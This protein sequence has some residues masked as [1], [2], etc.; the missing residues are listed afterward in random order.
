MT[1]GR[2][3]QVAAM[4]APMPIGG[5]RRAIDEITKLDRLACFHSRPTE[6]TR[7][8]SFG[9]TSARTVQTHVS[10]VRI[11]STRCGVGI[12]KTVECLT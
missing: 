1:T 4:R 10:S 3:N 8:A 12:C 9:R 7:R 6:T 5:H 2:I 11:P